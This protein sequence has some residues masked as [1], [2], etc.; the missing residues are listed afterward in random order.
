M[1]LCQQFSTL[2]SALYEEDAELLRMLEI[3]RLGT[4]EKGGAGDGE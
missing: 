1:G 2:P 4:K 3:I